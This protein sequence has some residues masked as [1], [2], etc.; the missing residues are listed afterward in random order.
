MEDAIL[1]I[2]NIKKNEEGPEFLKI[3]IYQIFCELT[4]AKEKFCFKWRPS[5]FSRPVSNN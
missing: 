1:K 3:E 2:Y 4:E 5:F